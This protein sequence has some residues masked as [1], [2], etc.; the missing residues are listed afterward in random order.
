[1]EKTITDQG[2]MTDVFQT[3]PQKP[4]TGSRKLNLKKPILTTGAI[5]LSGSAFTAILLTG[6]KPQQPPIPDKET[7][8]HSV[9]EGTHQVAGGTIKP[10][11]NIDI[12]QNIKEEMSFEQAY[13]TARQEVGPGGVFSW[14]GEIYNTFTQEEWQGMSLVQ[15]QDFLSDVG[16]IPSGTTIADNSTASTPTSTTIYVETIINGRPALGIDDDNDGMTDTILIMD[17]DTNSMYAIVNNGP[18]NRLD[19]LVQIDSST[20]EVVSVEPLKEPFTAEINKLEAMSE[21]WT[22]SDF[23]VVSLPPEE[24]AE[25]SEEVTEDASDEG[26]TNDA[27]TDDMD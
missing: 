4:Q 11:E 15:R 2:Q 8:G 20:Q 16:F 22:S 12:A 18:D 24:M 6:D 21:T 9:S 25:T 13:A 14:H 27:D 10:N 23:P 26:Y 19:T 1:M 5:L 3:V 17:I 7:T